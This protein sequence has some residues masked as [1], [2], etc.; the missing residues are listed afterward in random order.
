M[1][2]RQPAPPQP[3]AAVGKT[4]S[5]KANKK[6]P[7]STTKPSPCCARSSTDSVAFPKAS[8][9]P[10]TGVYKIYSSAALALHGYLNLRDRY[11]ESLEVLAQ[12]GKRRPR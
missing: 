6:P 1:N 7:T 3:S 11:D 8:A 10:G 2:A 9:N 5:S 4:Y 12:A